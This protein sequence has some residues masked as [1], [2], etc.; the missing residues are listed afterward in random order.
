MF[1][2]FYLVSFVPNTNRIK[3]LKN[4]SFFCL[5]FLGIKPTFSQ[6]LVPNWSFE[7][8]NICPD[9][10]GE[11]EYCNAWIIFKGAGEYFNSCDITNNYGV[12][13]NT[14]GF[15]EP[16]TGNAFAGIYTFSLT[17][18]QS[19]SF[20]DFIGVELID[21][22]QIGIKYYLNFKA[23]PAIIGSIPF[24]SDKFISNKLGG[25]LATYNYNPLPIL[26]FAHVFTDS[27]IRDSSIWTTIR[28]SFVADSNY[29]YL[30]LGNF[31]SDSL[32]SYEEINP[33][34]VFNYAY[35]Y[36]DDVCLSTDSV[37][38]ENFSSINEFNNEEEVNLF[39]NPCLNSISLS[40]NSKH[41]FQI[42]IV[43]YLG[44]II[45]STSLKNDETMELN[46]AFLSSGIYSVIFRNKSYS[47]EFKLVKLQ[48]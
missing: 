36:I 7:Q 22:L 32:T 38:C 37:L 47:R 4:Y 16:S 3:L 9:N 23:S 29:T 6:N 39:P 40:N 17:G 5:F 18:N 46:V 2:L 24:Q 28:G 35:Y 31:F 25:L 15:Q 30:I 42:D 20:R 10:H 11:I 14:C 13:Y 1:Y 19:N 41:Y 33:N 21:P 43:N 8:Y 34:G 48:N 27:I 26:N 44:E 12:P 45:I